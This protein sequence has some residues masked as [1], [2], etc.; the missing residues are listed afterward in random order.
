MNL[1]VS[2][3]WKKDGKKINFSS[4]NGYKNLNNRKKNVAILSYQGKIK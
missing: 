4:R 3:F 2:T 1:V